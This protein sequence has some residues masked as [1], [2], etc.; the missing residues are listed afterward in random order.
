MP[1]PVRVFISYSHDSP[2]HKARILALSNRLREEGVDCGIDQYEL[3]PAEGW[4]TWC[5]KQIE[6]ADF[7]LV[8]CTPTYSR[9]FR[10]EEE[11]GRGLGVTF[12]GHIVTQELYDAQGRNRK[13]IPVVFS[14]DDLTQIPVT[15]R[16]A[17]RFKLDDQYQGLYQLLTGQNPTPKPALGMPRQ[18]P[19]HDPL[20]VRET[21]TPAPPRPAVSFA[22]VER[23]PRRVFLCHAKADSVKV[24]EMYQR[25]RSD[26]VSPWLDEEE[27]VP[28]QNWEEEIGKAV[29]SS[30]AVMVFLSKASVASSRFVHKEINLALDVADSE[31]RG[32]IFVIPAR[33]ENCD[34][35][36]RI[37]HLHW[38]DLFQARGYEKL[39]KPLR[40]DGIIGAKEGHSLLTNPKDGM[41]YVWVPPGRF[42]MGA[43]EGDAEAR[44]NERPAHEVELSHGFWLGQTPVTVAAYERYREETG[45]PELPKE[46]KYGR[47]LNTAAGDPSLPVVAVTWYEAAAYCKWAGGRL[48]SEAEWE[49]AAR[50]GNPNARYG[51]IDEIAWYGDN[52]GNTRIDSAAVWAKDP[53]ADRYHKTLK[54]NGNGPKSVGLLEP[55]AWGLCDVLGNVWEWTADYFDE[56]YYQRREGR[57]PKGP[58][59][60]ST[61]ALRGGSWSAD[62]SIVRASGREGIVPGFRGLNVGFRCLWEKGFP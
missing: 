21:P 25:L 45:A 34:V 42:M 12:E 28:G 47:A 1:S 59:K 44:D 48:P 43:S 29:R 46:D 53:D 38:V 51:V 36:E 40:L 54:A 37:R 49:C 23:D 60:G 2:E 16:G 56:A 4:P 17:S 33:F 32:A 30:S 62:P 27:L 24:R 31:P 20:P 26:G 3:S 6:E 11:P 52:S 41:K 10:K 8:A 19:V 15:L 39:L 50:A 61:R 14:A 9:R 22:P 57:D 18:M 35:P 13:F 58:A 5:N 55:N 7:V